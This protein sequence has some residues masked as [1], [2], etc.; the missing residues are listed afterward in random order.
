MPDGTA[1]RFEDHLR[2]ILRALGHWLVTRVWVS[3]IAGALW[4]AGLRFLHVPLALL[5]A[6]LAGLLQFIPHFGPALALIPPAIAAAVSGGGE[7][8]VLVLILY[9][10]ITILTGLVIE[11]LL[12]KRIARVPVWA[13]LLFPIVLGLLFSFWGVIA[14]APLL[15]VFYAYRSG[16]LSR[17]MRPD[18]RCREGRHLL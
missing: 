12:F 15:A 14:A 17:P 1:M 11:P 6:I 10:A 7:R 2:L 16:G 18:V 3:L 13:S 9:A 8:F 5:W 4:W